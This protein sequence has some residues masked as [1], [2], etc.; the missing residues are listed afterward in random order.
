MEAV[1]LLASHTSAIALRDLQG[2]LLERVIQSVIGNDQALVAVN[3]AGAITEAGFEA[4]AGVSGRKMAGDTYGGLIPHGDSALS[5]KDPSAPSRAGSYMARFVA[6][7]L[8]AEGLAESALV[9]VAYA[10]GREEPVCL[11]ARGLGAKSRGVKMD[12]T[13]V[14]RARFDFR[15]EAIVERLGL[16]KPIYR[17]TA[18]YGHFGRLG[19]PWE[20]RPKETP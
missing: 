5:G 19:F 2:A 12:L 6:N 4:G 14:V 7:D 16:R 3:P 17:H 20:E 8:V 10:A 9:T 11:E 1:T 18:A 15:P 13:E